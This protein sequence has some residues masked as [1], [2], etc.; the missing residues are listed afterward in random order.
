MIVIF[1]NVSLWLLACC[2]HFIDM[3]GSIQD[4][5]SVANCLQFSLVF[6]VIAFFD[7]S[8]VQLMVI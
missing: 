4:I 3:C 8:Q 1:F 5:V 6:E 2:E 7:V